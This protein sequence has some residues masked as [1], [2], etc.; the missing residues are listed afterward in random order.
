MTI[1]HASLAADNPRLAA[2]VLAKIMGGGA[3]PFPPGGK[4]TWM[5]WS[6]DD[7]IELEIAPR[8]LDMAPSPQGGN[9]LLKHFDT[10]RTCAAHLAIAVEK[11]LEEITAVATEAGWPTAIFDRGD[12]FQVAEVWVEGAFLIEF[13]GPKQLADYRSKM[14]RA[15][16]KKTFAI[17]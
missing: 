9:W 3:T 4:E 6:A 11:N 7:S 16:W 15:N 14:S 5:A 1:V 2:E 17:P 13:L 12:Y 10:R 8:G